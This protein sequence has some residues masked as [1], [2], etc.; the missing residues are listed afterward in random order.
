MQEPA[1][2]G[3]YQV[4]GGG[5][6]ICPGNKLARMQITIMLHHLSIGYE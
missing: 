1:K 6:R 5:H 4:F 3:T 2:T